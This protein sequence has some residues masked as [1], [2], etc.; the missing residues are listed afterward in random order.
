MIRW[1]SIPWSITAENIQLTS[2]TLCTRL[3]SLSILKLWV[4]VLFQI[5]TRKQSTYW[6]PQYDEREVNIMCLYRRH[7]KKPVGFLPGWWSCRRACCPTCVRHCW[8]ATCHG[9]WEHIWG[10][11]GW[12]R[13][14]PGIQ[15]RSTRAPA[16]AWGSTGAAQTACSTW[17]RRTRSIISCLWFTVTWSRIESNWFFF[18]PLVYD[19]MSAHI[20]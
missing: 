12:S 2:V 3:F 15:P 7:R 13:K 6:L 1:L 10:L 4:S 14:Q 17:E 8:P 20:T 5:V 18:L 16:W 11:Q 19:L 9:A